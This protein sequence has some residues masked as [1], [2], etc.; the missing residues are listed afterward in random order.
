[1]LLLCVLGLM[2]VKW[3]D[4]S[5]VFLFLSIISGLFLFIVGG[6]LFIGKIIV[7]IVIVVRIKIK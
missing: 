6:W 5:L 2:I 4:V 7:I 3:C 1:M